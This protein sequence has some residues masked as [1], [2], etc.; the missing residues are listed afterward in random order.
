MIE[1]YIRRFRGKA[2][3]P[4]ILGEAVCDLN[5]IDSIHG[6]TDLPPASRTN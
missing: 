6:R 4:L 5:F 2:I 3:S 1:H